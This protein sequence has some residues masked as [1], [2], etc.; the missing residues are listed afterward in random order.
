MTR[1]TESPPE[2]TAV[3]FKSIDLAQ[4]RLENFSNETIGVETVEKSAKLRLLS[5]VVPEPPP[6]PAAHMAA[7]AQHKTRACRFHMMSSSDIFLQ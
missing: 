2:Q 6:H 7:K 1:E 4:I 5:V 3:L